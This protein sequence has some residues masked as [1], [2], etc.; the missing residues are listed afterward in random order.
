MFGNGSFLEV[1]HVLVDSGVLV[2]DE[3]PLLVVVAEER[4]ALEFGGTVPR[5][6]HGRGVFHA[7]DELPL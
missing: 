4:A 7:F 1:G 6:A 3:K 2:S 5:E